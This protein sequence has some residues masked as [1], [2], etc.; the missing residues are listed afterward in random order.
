M[1]ASGRNVF[2]FDEVVSG[3]PND[4]AG[5]GQDG[6]GGSTV[7]ASTPVLTFGF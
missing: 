3:R 5:H 1:L 7:S 4:P 6:F 2:Y